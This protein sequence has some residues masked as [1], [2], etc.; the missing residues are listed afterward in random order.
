MLESEQLLVAKPDY[1]CN[2]AL[3]KGGGSCE[4]CRLNPRA[5]R[6]LQSGFKS[7]WAPDAAPPK[8][9]WADPQLGVPLG[10]QDSEPQNFNPTS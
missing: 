5:S 2:G 6:C 9:P 8:H 1:P 10:L 7:P 4:L 3:G